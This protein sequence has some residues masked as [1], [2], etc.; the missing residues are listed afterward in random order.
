V[1]VKTASSP[2]GH[3]R[4]IILTV[5]FMF[6]LT[7]IIVGW[8]GTSS[9]VT[10]SVF[11][12]AVD[13]AREN[14]GTVID[15]EGLSGSF[16]NGVYFKNIKIKKSSPAFQI[17]ISEVS[18]KPDFSLLKKGVIAVTANAGIIDADGM[19][20]TSIASS[21]IPDYH[22]M[23]C[24]AA[25]PANLRLASLAIERI[26]LRPFNDFPASI[27]LNRI[28]IASHDNSGR[29]KVTINIGGKWRNNNVASGSFDGFLRQAEAKVEGSLSLNAAGQRIATE[30][31]LLNKR[32]ALE[33]SGYISSAAIDISHLSHWLIPIW[34][35]EFPVGFDGHL[36]CSG[37]W[38][39][40][41]K[42]GFLGN[43]TGEVRD[44]RAVAL[45]LF[46]SIF[47]LNG[48]WKFFDGNLSFEDSASLF[49]G[50]PA[51][52]TGKVE[53]AFSPDRRFDLK[54]FCNTIDFAK[55]YNDLPWGVK[56]GMAIPRLAGTATFSLQ[57]NGNRPEIDAKI[58]T[59][60]LSAGN[61]NDLRLVDGIIS[62]N[63]SAKGSGKF[64]TKMH[65]RLMNA[66][67][68]FYGRFKGQYGSMKK[69]ISEL[70]QPLLFSYSLSGNDFSMLRLSGELIASDQCVARATG[71]W[72]DGMGTIAFL[73]NAEANRAAQLFAGGNIPFLELILAK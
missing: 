51:A 42:L 56:Y 2:T 14:N 50:F 26:N 60:R 46:I 8:L 44:L 73:W 67:V 12:Y 32:G 40:A 37:S 63:L 29:Q 6:L 23:S 61:D 48:S 38:I 62:Y 17:N 31:N 36:S 22:G 15:Y 3:I 47:E 71:T 33:A 27:S 34:Q 49:F 68:P 1:S 64:L 21:T 9:K 28:K 7:G 11:Q 58:V 39:F 10:R 52:L 19:I 25:M 20:T 43:L 18:L 54:F 16:F 66:D 13:K 72:H 70:K 59:D 53:S 65:C 4:K 69:R 41:P 55:L 45:G 30:L 5:L 35:Q 24:F 57:L